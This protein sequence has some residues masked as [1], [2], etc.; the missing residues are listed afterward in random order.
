LVQFYID[1]M[2]STERYERVRHIPVD[3]ITNLRDLG[4]FAT[5]DGG[6]TTWQR[7]YRAD[8][9]HKL[10]A[11]GLATFQA[12]G[13]RSVFDLRGDVERS[14]FPNPVPSVHAPIVGRPAGQ[15]PASRASVIAADDGE[16]M[17]LDTYIGI[18][19]HSASGI[20]TILS[21][22]TD[23]SM[24]PALFHCHGGKDRTG[25]V[26]AVLLTALGVSR[27]DVLDDYEATRRYR[28]IAHQQ[29]SYTNM[30]ANGMSPEAAAGAL[31]TPR[32]VMAT[33][34]DAIDGRYGGVDRYLLDVVGLDE[35]QIHRLR[36][37]LVEHPELV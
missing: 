15:M 32:W 29:D 16:R 3:G 20:A 24:T 7:V 5:A 2:E 28:T 4:G 17:L 9:L 21:A 22:L 12:L 30:L 36:A 23:R 25:V 18:L 37:E 33:V 6:V 19:E 31:G 27:D 35:A 8:A 26:A 14:E 10:T 11:D 1:R 34:L 13:V